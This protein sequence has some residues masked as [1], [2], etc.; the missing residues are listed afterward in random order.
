MSN[1]LTLREAIPT[2]A[3]KLLEFFKKTQDYEYLEAI[4]TDTT[5]EEVMYS[6]DEIYESGIDELTLAIINDEIVGFARVEGKLSTGEVG[7][8]VDKEF[9]GK[10]IGNELMYD[11]V[12]WF[13][14]YSDLY[15]IWLEVYT[16]NKKAINLYKKYNFV[17]FHKTDN[18]KFMI[19]KKTD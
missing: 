14:N 16:E 1:E 11:I 2:D 4:N 7:I 13:E 3:K 19:L 5:E 10:G 6:L 8:V 12:D 15:E 17:E 9:Q 18:S